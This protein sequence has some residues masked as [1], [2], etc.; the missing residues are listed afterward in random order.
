MPIT[1]RS[2]ARLALLAGLVLSL[3]VPARGQDKPAA[4]GDVGETTLITVVEVPVR[5]LLKG[6][7]V[8]GLS[9]ED[10]Q[11]LDD[12]QPREI[13][14][15]EVIDSGVA[16]GTPSP[17]GDEADSE[18]PPPAGRNVLILFDLAYGGNGQVHA[19][20]R[21]IE[22]SEAARSFVDNAMSPGDQ[23]AVAYYSPLRGFKQLTDFTDDQETLRFALHGID[24]ILNGKPKLV[25]EEF[26]GW[27]QL[28]PD[29][30][31]YRGRTP[32]GP[33]R[34]SLADLTM[35]ARNS[36]LRGDPF[37]W[38]GLIIK[39]FAWGLREFTQ[40]NDLPGMNHIMLFSSGPLFGD[41]TTRA[42]FY[43]Q[44]LFRDLRQENWSIQ[45]IDTG[46]LGFGR[47][48]LSLLTG[49]ALHTN[50][51]DLELLLLE[52][53]EETRHSYMLTF[54]VI[55]LP[56]DGHYRKLR[57]KLTN[58]PK[59][60]KLTHRPGY[61]EPGG[62]DPKWRRSLTPVGTERLTD[63]PALQGFDPVWLV[64][65]LLEEGREDLALVHRDFRYLFRNEISLERF[66]AD[67]ERYTIH[68]FGN[69]P[70][71]A[72]FQGDPDIF[73]VQEGKIYI[74]SSRSA[75]RKFRKN[76]GSF[77]P[78]LGAE[79]SKQPSVTK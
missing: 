55:D 59:K 58:G 76:P 75:R 2:A 1:H 19:S 38:H 24:L 8:L 67:P 6:E 47:D 32:L 60:A 18:L 41:E 34:A 46:E 70:V 23:V 66:L 42:L 25:Q 45:A 56:E 40:A 72:E 13:T 68:N 33:N 39:H 5:V 64:G 9:A 16:R 65:G 74:F 20:R 35:E 63:Y 71:F 11:I 4:E 51:R 78:G 62:I 73:W 44:E 21:L 50:S 48:S 30:Q 53:V 12:G 49:G 22:A 14:G 57:V 15:F 54:Q 79:P 29:V 37:L 43:L 52:A 69:C 31:G 77:V 3:A 36:N 27:A 10:F 7:P 26:Y 61:Y 17:S 28:G